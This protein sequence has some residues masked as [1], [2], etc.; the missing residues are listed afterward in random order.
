MIDTREQRDERL[1]DA[2]QVAQGEVAFVE[3]TFF[4][5]LADD[6]FDESLDGFA[7]AGGRE[8]ANR[9]IFASRAAD[10]GHQQGK[11]DRSPDAHG[12]SV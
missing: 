7:G 9:R 8:N 4:E 2:C 12:R 5:A 10:T 3:L 6:A 1:L 11:D